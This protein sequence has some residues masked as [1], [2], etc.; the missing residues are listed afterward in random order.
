MPRIRSSIAAAI[1]VTLTIG[2]EKRGE[3]D[4]PA[5]PTPPSG[6]APAVPAVDFAWYDVAATRSLAD[7][8]A[9]QAKLAQAA[10]KQPFAYLHADWCPPCKAIEQTVRRDERMIRAF[11]GTHIISIDIDAI[12]PVQIDAHGLHSKSIPAFFRL[13]G[14]GAPTGARI[15]GGAWQEDIPANMAPPLAAFFAGR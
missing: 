4:E 10:G 11:A 13:D 15:D 3:R 8:L 2:C 12:D 1:A 14:K 6:A 7:E 5:P 9:A